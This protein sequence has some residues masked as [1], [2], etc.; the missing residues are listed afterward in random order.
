MVITDIPLINEVFNQAKAARQRAH[1][2]YSKFK[3]GSAV[4]LANSDQIYSGCNVE[5]A[6]FGA[7]VCSERITLFSALAANGRVDFEYMVLVAD[8]SPLATPCGECLQVISEFVKPDF[9]IYLANLEGIQEKVL[10][11]DLLPRGFTE[12]S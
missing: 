10:L 1:S 3:V 8:I 7:T 4:K 2:P 5:N 6:S 9:P 12:F 11:K